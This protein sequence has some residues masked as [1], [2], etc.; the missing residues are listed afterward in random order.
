MHTFGVY[1][2]SLRC[3]LMHRV[4][5][6]SLYQIL[7][8]IHFSQDYSRR[9]RKQLLSLRYCR[10]FFFFLISNFKYFY[11]CVEH[12]SLICSQIPSAALSFC[13]ELQNLERKL[14]LYVFLAYADTIAIK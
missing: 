11:E 9:L 5:A 2:S 4:S 3:L 13:P 7:Y 12:I 14:V 10:L 1:S 8:L 6:V